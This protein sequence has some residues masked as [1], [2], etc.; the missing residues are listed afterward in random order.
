MTAIGCESGYCTVQF[1]FPCHKT[2]APE[3]KK[4]IKKQWRKN[5]NEEKNTQKEACKARQKENR[6]KAAFDRE[7]KNGI[8][9][10]SIWKVLTP[11]R[12]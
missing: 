3:E 10:G 2:V 1:S 6:K 5:K 7:C 12:R 9:L 8:W 11:G 4:I